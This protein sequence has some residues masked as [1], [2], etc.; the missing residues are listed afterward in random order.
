MTV[1]D[2]YIIVYGKSLELIELSN[3]NKVSKVLKLSCVCLDSLV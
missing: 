3:T 2:L 1:L